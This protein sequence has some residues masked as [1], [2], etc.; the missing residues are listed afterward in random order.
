MVIKEID[1]FWW[2]RV[3]FVLD[4]RCYFNYLHKPTPTDL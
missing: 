3:G 2:G 1:D 4:F